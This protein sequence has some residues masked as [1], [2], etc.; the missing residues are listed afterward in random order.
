MAV[1]EDTAA[2][3]ATVLT[4]QATSNE[5]DKVDE[6]APTLHRSSTV[7]TPS[8]RPGHRHRHSKRLSLN[9][10]IL[11]PTQD[12]PYTNGS[13]SSMSQSPTVPSPYRNG[14]PLM[15]N[16]PSPDESIAYGPT[17]GIPDFLTLIAG[18]ERRVMEL[19]E[20]LQKAET[21]LTG[22]KKQWTVFE[23]KKK[24]EELR[25][26]T[27]K[28]GPVS[29]KDAVATAE[30]E[31]A[32]RARRREAREKRLRDLG[33]TEGGLG[34][35]NSNNGK[36]NGQRV[37][38]GRH[39]R[40]L[41]LLQNNPSVAEIAQN[42][43]RPKSKTESSP[44]SAHPNSASSPP[45]VSETFDDDGVQQPRRSI[46]RQPTLQELISSSA[47]GAAQLNLGKTYKDLANASRKSLPPG[48]D[49]LVKQGKQVYDGVSQGFW[50]F[51]EDIRQ[52][53]VGDEPVNG[54]PPAQQKEV[55]KTRSSK[56]LS[57][58]A[59]D[60]HGKHG[61]EHK[62]NK[63]NKASDTHKPE[64]D[65]FWNEFGIETPKAVKQA[66]KQSGRQANATKDKDSSASHPIKDHESKSST[67]SKCPPSLLAD[68]M[69]VNEEED[70]WDSWPVESPVGQRRAERSVE[71]RASSEDS[72]SEG[73]GRVRKSVKVQAPREDSDSEAISR[74]RKGKPKREFSTRKGTIE[75]SWA[76]LTT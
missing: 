55:R 38:E 63:K 67:D 49:L 59:G 24:H 65:S 37:F 73:I 50:N 21:V 3:K 13:T 47:T 10:P 30:D 17:S 54:A 48:T 76:E 66:N 39:T 57:E 9:F 32:E 42:A 72:D 7:Q 69:D 51:V 20:E 74:V 16:L 61:S 26:K 70:A 31:D 27:V 41:S 58:Q 62:S 75:T 5:A 23:A 19:K 36:R 4:T 6:L 43:N 64:K 28:V 44:S 45:L 56:K 11:V 12:A 22:L 1:D 14:T 71:I 46:S 18:Q 52:A 15:P 2:A 25:H 8:G 35:S 68:V 34:R 40:T 53:T 60:K 33:M 29:P